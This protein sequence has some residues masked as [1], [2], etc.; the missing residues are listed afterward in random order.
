M[1][2]NNLNITKS[3]NQNINSD[4][5]YSLIK[6]NFKRVNLQARYEVSWIA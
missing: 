5:V 2:N 6:M 3:L 4:I 1:L